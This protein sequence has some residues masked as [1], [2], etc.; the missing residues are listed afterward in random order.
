[1]INMEEMIVERN[2]FFV[3]DDREFQVTPPTLTPEQEKIQ[4]K[5][6][7]EVAAKYGLDADEE[8]KSED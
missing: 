2:E 4:E 3:M 7:R 5:I 1:M 6:L 8:E